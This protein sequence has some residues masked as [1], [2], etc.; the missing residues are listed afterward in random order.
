MATPYVG[1]SPL[2]WLDWPF[3]DQDAWHDFLWAHEQWHR[4]LEGVAQQAPFNHT[5]VHFPLDDL[6][7][8]PTGHQQMHDGLADGF[9][10]ARGG[11]LT[12]VDFDV[13]DQFQ[14]WMYVHALDHQ[15]FRL[16]AGV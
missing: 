13:E 15:R 9:G 16:V 7:T 14:T 11:D 4:V 5:V 8:N 1:M 3:K 12:T 10:I 6:S 2:L